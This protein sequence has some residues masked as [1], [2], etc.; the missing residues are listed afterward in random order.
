MPTSK[1]IN[2]IQILAEVLQQNALIMFIFI[3]EN[4]AQVVYWCEAIYLLTAQYVHM[5]IEP[6][7][8]D[9]TEFLYILHVLT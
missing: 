2:H 4:S 6:E 9:Q 8:L 5:I 1:C 7:M 3:R